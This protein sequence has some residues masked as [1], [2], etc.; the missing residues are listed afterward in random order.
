MTKQYDLSQ[1]GLRI[2]FKPWQIPLVKL[3][4]GHTFTDRNP[5]RTRDA[6]ININ[7]LLPDG[8][9]IS[10]ASVIFFLQKLEEM[11]WLDSAKR[12]GRGGHHDVYWKTMPLNEF[13]TTKLVGL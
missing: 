8:E 3:I 6:F 12:T 1:D 2:F 10:R 4:D 9:S 5:L 13:I 11:G 7:K